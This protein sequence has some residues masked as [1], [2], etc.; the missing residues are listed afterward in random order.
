MVEDLGLSAVRN[1]KIS[2]LTHSERQRLN[3]SCQLLGQSSI[4]ILDQITNNLDIFD[5]FFLVEYLKYW[6]NGSRLVIMTLQPP[7]FEIYSMCTNI[8]LLSKGRVI[9]SG[10]RY[11]LSQHMSSMGYP[12]PPYKNPAD[13]YRKYPST[14]L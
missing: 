12:C 7:T 10:P 8:V 5:T 1:T 14:L 9:Y 2:K 3:I 11:Y 6:C 13:Y 4:L